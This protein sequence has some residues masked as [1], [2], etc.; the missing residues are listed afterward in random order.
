MAKAQF[1]KHENSRRL[2]RVK[3]IVT[4]KQCID[5]TSQSVR[6]KVTLYHFGL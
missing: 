2:L 5:V 1:M 4:R 3:T 6:D